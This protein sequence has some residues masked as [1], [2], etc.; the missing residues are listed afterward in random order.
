MRPGPLSSQPEQIEQ[1][2]LVRAR[3]RAT[4][5]PDE[6]RAAARA[7]GTRA[8]SRCHGC[9]RANAAQKP[10]QAAQAGQQP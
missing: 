2:Q 4:E 8:A 10:T 6:R 5:Q 9:R 1:P 7:A 3:A